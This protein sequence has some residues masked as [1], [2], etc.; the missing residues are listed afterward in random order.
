MDKRRIVIT[1]MGAVTPLG[2]TVDEFWAGLTAGKSGVGYITRFDATN[3]SVKVAAEITDF[4][5]EK[6]MDIKMVDRSARFTQFA[7]AASKMAVESAKLDFLEI[8][9]ERVGVSIATTMDIS[10]ITRE[11]EVIKSR[12]PR[13]VSPLFVT[14]I[15]PHMASVQVGLLFDA[16]GPNSSVNSA[17]ASG[18]DA[19]A[20]AH[21]Y[22]Q[23]GYADVMLAGGTDATI[24]ELLVAS[25]GLLGALSREINPDKASRP[26][27]LNRDGFVA[28][29]GSAILVLETL[30]H[31]MV[32][33]AP[34]L[35]ELAGVARSFDAY[36][37]AA[38][39]PE[40]QAMAITAAIKNAGIKPEDIDYV[41]AH[42]T[43][44]RLND[45]SETKAIKIALGEHAYKIPVS[46]NKSMLGHII[47]AAG[48]V[49][50]MASILTINHGII[51]P[52]INYETLDP[53]CDLDY[54]PNVAR[55]ADVNV[56]LSNS[57]GMGG[58]NCCLV[59]K[60]F[61]G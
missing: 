52:T 13:R 43:G 12:G 55:P 44:T 26:F 7:I 54:V 19:L 6:Y 53:D 20:T 5:P 61:T 47:T 29:E 49:E 2:L 21:D 56:C 31:A 51:P 9:P 15:G 3:F 33:G 16:K 23:L 58:Q 22:I 8:R 60:R 4:E 39:D 17:C 59:I 46:S 38:P 50:A 40:V 1:G 14:R 10:G 37:E 36:N 34:I 25:M 28:G 57:F 48:A 18:S 41:N 45:A 32:R 11:H 24:N 42:G 27:D 35:A 30:E